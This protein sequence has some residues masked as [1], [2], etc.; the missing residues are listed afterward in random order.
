MRMYLGRFYSLVKDLRVNVEG[1]SRQGLQPFG[2]EE[3][4]EFVEKLGK[5][6]SIRQ[7]TSRTC[8][9]HSPRWHGTL[10]MFPLNRRF[11]RRSAV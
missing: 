10:V 1:R 3:I 6:I 7:R 9:P 2:L 8:C 11:C 4:T 5:R